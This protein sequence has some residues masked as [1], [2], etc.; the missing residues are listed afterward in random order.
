MVYTELLLYKLTKRRFNRNCQNSNHMALLSRIKLPLPRGVQVA[1]TNMVLPTMTKVT[2]DKY[3]HVFK[4]W[5]YCNILKIR[6]F[7]W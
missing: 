3:I 4:C 6:Q 7:S 2:G 1:R 5:G